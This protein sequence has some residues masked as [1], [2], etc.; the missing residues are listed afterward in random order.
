MNL[1]QKDTQTK[2]DHTMIKNVKT[3][4]YYTSSVITLNGLKNTTLSAKK[5]LVQL[6]QNGNKDCIE[7]IVSNTS[8]LQNRK[9]HQI[10]PAQTNINPHHSTLYFC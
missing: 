4:F 1:S 9:K 2:C 10:I 8:T 3:I 6:N 7:L 5:Y